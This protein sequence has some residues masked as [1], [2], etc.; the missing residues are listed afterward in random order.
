[1]FIL[2]RMS[3]CC[4]LQVIFL[5]G[6]PQKKAKFFRILFSSFKKVLFILVARPLQPPPLS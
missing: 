6:K 2:N 3:S 1:M 4:P 5:L